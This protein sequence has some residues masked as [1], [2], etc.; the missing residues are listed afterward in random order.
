MAC[1]AAMRLALHLAAQRTGGRGQHDGKAHLA[2][3]D[4]HVADHLQR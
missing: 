4:M 3:V 1:T 2:A